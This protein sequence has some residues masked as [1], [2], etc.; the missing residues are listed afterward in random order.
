MFS[1]RKGGFSPWDGTLNNQPHRNLKNSGYLLGIS[2]YIYIIYPLSKGSLGVKQLGALHP[3]G[4]TIFP[5]I[6]RDH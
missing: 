2:V 5:V 3:K 1:H 6:L 4:T